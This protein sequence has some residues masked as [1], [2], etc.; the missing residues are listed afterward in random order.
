M[1][2]ENKLSKICWNTRNW[3]FPSGPGGKSPSSSS[4]ESKYGF[5]HE[6]WLRDNSRIIDGFHFAFLQ[7][8]NL[9]TDRH[10]GKKYHIKL[11]TV[12]NSTKYFVGTINN[13]I[14]ISKEESKEVYKLYKKNGWL[15][16]MALDVENAG[17]DPTQLKNTPPEIYFN[18]KFRFN[19]F[20]PTQ[21]GDLE[22]IS[23]NDLN[24]TTNRYKLL[25]QKKDLA[26][27][28][29]SLEHDG[30]LK[31]TRKRKRTLA[32]DTTFDP[33]HDKI[34]NAL[35][36][37]LRNKYSELYKKVD[38][39]KNRIDVKALTC[40]GQ[41]H[42]YE[43]KTDNPKLSIRKGIG[44]LLEYAFYPKKEIAQKLIIIAD[45]LP[46][47]STQTYLAHIRNIFSIPVF[48]QSFNLEKNELSKEY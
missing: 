41:W 25:S 4:Y 32:G 9:K 23:E 17:A 42:F 15:K 11:F 35:C 47:K 46:N 3:K 48:Y 34:Q 44:Q 40:D 19:D 8:L 21:S 28:T 16:E 14:C 12:L 43:V 24:I 2:I 10:V 29:E 7:P 33:V 37:L 22:E 31:N 18:V 20:T 26:F 30:N 13:A 39:E 6:E 36:N 5:G 38:I 45:S 27:T 1:Q